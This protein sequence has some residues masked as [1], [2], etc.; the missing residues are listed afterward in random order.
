MAREVVAFT[1]GE[2]VEKASSWMIGVGW[3]EKV[4]VSPFIEGRG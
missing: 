4:G 2:R 3:W 1:K